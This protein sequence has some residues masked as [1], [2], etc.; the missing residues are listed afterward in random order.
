MAKDGGYVIAG[1]SGGFSNADVILIKTNSDGDIEWSK[2]FGG[3]K[4]DIAYSVQ[5]TSDDGF[6]LTGNI[7]KYYEFNL[8][9]LLIKTDSEGN[10]PPIN[11]NNRNKGV[12]NSLL[13]WFLERFPLLER[14]L[15]LIK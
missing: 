15:N 5:Q 1:H 7:Q 2:I 12:I 10:A 14:L 8:D 6:I 9:V 11:K 3:V 4:Q 13:L